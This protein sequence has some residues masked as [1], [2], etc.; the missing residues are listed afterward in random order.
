MLM[1]VL[2]NLPHDLIYSENQ[3]SSWKEVWVER[4]RDR[5][6][7]SELYKPLKDSL[8]TLKVGTQRHT[9]NA[10][11]FGSSNFNN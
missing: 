3:V 5:D 6:T 1:M 9:Y 8:I 2:D 4:Q 7:L 10:K 11:G